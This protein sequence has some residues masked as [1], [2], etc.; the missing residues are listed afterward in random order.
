MGRWLSLGLVVLALALSHTWQAAEAIVRAED[1]S[2]F[3]IWGGVKPQAALS[4]AE[5]LYILQGHVIEAKGTNNPKMV[6]VTQGMNV[7]RLTRGKVWLVYRAD[8]LR[9]TPPVMAGIVARLDEWRRHGNPVVGLQIDFD[10]RTR[11][12]REYAGFLR[13]VRMELPERYLL[14]IT[15]LLDWSSTGDV[16][17]INGLRNVIDEVVVQTYQGRRTIT[18]YQV[19]LPALRRLMLPFKV[20][21][22]QHGEWEAPDYLESNPWFRGY[23]VFLRNEA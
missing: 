20:G 21:V 3:W 7:A 8:T 6:V 2:S 22:V 4:Q 12:L 5:S 1:Y 17:T 18:N 16:G 11:H 10:A 9:W 15:G 14:G 19:Y 13:K 23:V